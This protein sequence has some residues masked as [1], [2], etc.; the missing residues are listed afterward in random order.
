[1]PD[2]MIAIPNPSRIASS[3]KKRCEVASAFRSGSQYLYW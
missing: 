2:S 1:M 3:V